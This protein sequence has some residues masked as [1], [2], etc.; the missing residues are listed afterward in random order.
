MPRDYP[1][2]PLIGVGAVVLRGDQVLLI[3]RAKPP[4]QGEWSLPGG[5]QKLGETI[6]D[7]AARE[8]LEETGVTARPFSIIDVVDLIERDSDTQ[9]RVRW[10]YTLIDVLALWQ[11][12]EPRPAADAA[13]ARWFFV[14]DVREVVEWSET[15]R[16]VEK[17]YAISQQS[18][19]PAARGAD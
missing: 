1:R 8:V 13:E 12:G 4:R 5:L 18:K 16:I 15:A 3:R 6:Y 14:P 19:D 2:V 10:H 11:A 7:A 17:A 9:A